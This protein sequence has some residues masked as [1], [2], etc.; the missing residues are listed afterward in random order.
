MPTKK[1]KPAEFF[2]DVKPNKLLGIGLGFKEESF[3][4]VMEYGS[5]DRETSGTDKIAVT[6]SVE[7]MQT[8]VKALFDCGKAYQKQFGTDIGFGDF[9]EEKQ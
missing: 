8:V 2:L 7:N 1:K 4:M 9:E 6:F 5:T 3:L